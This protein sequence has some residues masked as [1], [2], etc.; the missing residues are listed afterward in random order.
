M[1]RLERVLIYFAAQYLHQADKIFVL[2]NS[3]IEEQGTWED[4][5]TSSGYISKLQL[6]TSKTAESVGLTSSTEIA[7]PISTRL[8][9]KSSSPDVAELDHPVR[10]GD[11]SVYCAF[12][13]KF[14]QYFLFN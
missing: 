9:S 11:L 1:E 6:A 10:T 4:L 14:E 2:G 5:R 8:A 13:S 3:G 12:S 7:A